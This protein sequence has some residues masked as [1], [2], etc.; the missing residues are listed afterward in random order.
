MAYAASGA[1]KLMSPVW[2]DGSAITG[3]FRTRTYG[4]EGLYRLLNLH[5]AIPRI[6]AWSVVLGELTFPLVLVAPKPVARGILGM[7]VLFHLSIGRFMGL[8]RFFWAF[9]ATCPAVAYVSR[10]LRS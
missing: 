7:G 3:I 9:T 4:G 2:R 8:N 10:S 1:I 6:V 5:P